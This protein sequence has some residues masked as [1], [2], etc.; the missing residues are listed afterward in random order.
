MGHLT[1][2]PFERSDKHINLS[3]Y[4]IKIIN[5][6]KKAAK[7]AISTICSSI[8]SKKYSLL[9]PKLIS[10]Y[11]LTYLELRAEFSTLISYGILDFCGTV[12]NLILKKYIL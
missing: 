7:T 4:E 9:G 10:E 12:Y 1:K 8:V 2:F 6:E 5:Y 11:L 3:T